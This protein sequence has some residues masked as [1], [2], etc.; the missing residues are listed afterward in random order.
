MAQ[1]M[2]QHTGVPPIITQQAQPAF[3]QP[4][5]QSQHAWIMSQH[6]LSPVVQVRQ[7]PLVVISHLQVH[8]VMLQQHTTMPF[9]VQH[10]LHIPPAIMVQRFC[11]MVQAAGSSQAQV[12]FIP[13]AHFSTFIV[14]RGTITMFGVMP[15][16]IGIGIP[17]PM[18]PAPVVA[19]IGFIIAVTMIVSGRGRVGR[20]RW[21]G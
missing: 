10:T 16:G 2:Q 5:T 1:H 15:V 3:M 20:T 9:M 21:N 6:V 13:P 12:T 18:L 17:M 8:M 11:I 14:Q 4:M 7:Q 19:L